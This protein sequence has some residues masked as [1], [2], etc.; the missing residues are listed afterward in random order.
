M[1]SKFAMLCIVCACLAG[2]S[3]TDEAALEEQCVCGTPTVQDYRCQPECRPMVR[4][5]VNR[6]VPCRT[7]PQA[8][9][10]PEQYIYIQ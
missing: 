7:K 4:P 8:I 2:C 6:T 5:V 3:T 9:R 1:K 10:I